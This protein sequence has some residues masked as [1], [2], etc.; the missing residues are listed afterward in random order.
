VAVNRGERPFLHDGLDEPLK[1]LRRGQ[2]HRAYRNR[3]RGV[4]RR[5]LI[6][7][8]LLLAAAAAGGGA[9]FARYYATHAARFRLRRIG[10]SSLRYAP[11]TELRKAMTRYAGTNIFRLDLARAGRDLEAKRWIKRATVRRVLPDGLFCA[12]EERRPRGLALIRDRVWLVDEEGVAIDPYGDTGPRFSFPIFIGLAERDA[13]RQRRQ[14]ERG[15]RLLEWMDASHPG[16]GAEISEIDLSRDDRIELR[17]NDGG[18]VV[19]LHP[20]DFGNNLD[21]YL[22]MRDYLA[23][24]FGNGEYVDLRFRDRIAFRPAVTREN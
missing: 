13:D 21:R 16:L 11:E 2:E 15:V 8:A 6:A 9:F 4:V 17:M 14:V 19:R 23:T 7:A 18:P 22:T 10:F 20:T 1:I 24:D 5:R 12:I 3:H